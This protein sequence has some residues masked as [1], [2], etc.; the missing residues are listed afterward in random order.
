MKI[1]SPFKPS[2]TLNDLKKLLYDSA[3]EAGIQDIMVHTPSEYNDA[4]LP[5]SSDSAI[6]VFNEIFSNSVV[7]HEANNPSVYI[8]VF[9]MDDNTWCIRFIDDSIT[10]MDIQT[11]RPR[12]IKLNFPGD[13]SGDSSVGKVRFSKTSEWIHTLHGQSELLPRYYSPGIIFSLKFPGHLKKSA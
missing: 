1:K 7:S 8:S 12:E 3:S 5:F 10:M 4:P 2:C 13:E 6:E 9:L 11:L